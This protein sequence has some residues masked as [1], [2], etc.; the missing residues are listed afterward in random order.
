VNAEAEDSLREAGKL[1]TG[2]LAR[3][4]RV[5]GL[6]T[7]Q[8]LRWAGMRTANRVRTPERAAAAQ[9]ERTLALVEQI[10]EQLG[11]M[12]GAAMKI[13]QMLSMVEFDGVPEDQ[14][15]TL[16]SKFAALRDDVPPVA[17]ADLERL[18]RHELGGPLER[19]FSDFD[20][21]ALAAASIGQVHRALTLDG[22]DVAVKVQY[23]GVAEAVETDLRNAML[24]IPLVKRLA[25]GLDARALASELRERI[26]EELDYEL[27]AQNQR[28]IER[29]LRGHPFVRIPR[30]R[31]DLTTRRVMVSEY[32]EG[33]RFE[34]VRRSADAQRDR[35]GEIVFRFFFGLLYRER[36]A[37]GD[38]HPGNY[39]LTADGRVCFLDFGLL[40]DVD[41]ARLSAERAIAL[42]VRERDAP[43]LKTALQ[44]GGYLPAGR[45]DAVD[46]ELVLEMMRVA[47][48]WYSAPGERRF[49]P[50][51]ARRDRERKRP[52]AEQHAAIR[53]Q[54]NQ[55]TLPPETI[56]IR[57]MHG[58][59]AVVLEQ[60]RAG[61]NWGA[62][63]AEYLHGAPPASPL[64]QAEADFFAR[65]GHR[66][67]R[68]P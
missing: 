31:L 65:R 42:A 36:I 56:L 51:S 41:P 26:A 21:Q 37:L 12:R 2:R 47:T 19:V 17:F 8:G 43:A 27:E 13:G 52:D 46:A 58:V 62:I 48:R 49:S 59:V 40:R 28:R 44:T 9:S 38:P 14:R 22:E 20:E 4:A 45:A 15:E 33:Q 7:G 57:R 3:T 16:Q 30:V 11:Q 10:V 61:A 24:L 23:P 6:V 39:L 64:G 53:A 68:A 32:V 29:M 55:F 67:T 35:Y 66:A 18:M 5:G 50:A 60:L 34:Q 54:L 1:P 63:A 25:P